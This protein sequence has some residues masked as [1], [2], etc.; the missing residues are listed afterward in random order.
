M[1]NLARKLWSHGK[2]VPARSFSFHRPLLLIQSDDWGRVGVRDREGYEQ[3]RDNGIPLGQNPYDLYTLETA[4]DVSALAEMLRQHRDSTGRSACLLMNFVLANV[5]FPRT[6]RNNYQQIHL[7]SLTEG[8]PGNWKRPG[9]FEAYRKGIGDGL[10]YP[11]LHG[12][13]HFCQQSVR[14]HLAN[15]DER[16]ALLRTL[17]KAETPY[18]YWRMPWV[19]YEY[20]NPEPPRAGFL[21]AQT[22]EAL[23]AAAAESFQEFFSR[24]PL[25]ACAPG[26]RA[27]RETRVAWSKQGVR[28]AQNGSGSPLPPHFDDCEILNLHRTIDVEPSQRELPIEKYVQLA[29]GC[30]ARGVPTIVSVHSIN[31][32]ST[33][34]DFR[35]PTLRALD[36]F[37]SALERKYPD[38]LYVHDADVY[39]IVSRGEFETS[40]GKVSVTVRQAPGEFRSATTT[41]GLT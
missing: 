33:L 6:R 26:Y 5:D 9:L 39:D 1:L 8:L 22:Q 24:P 19:G 36:E 4:E 15:Q 3:L 13:T 38:L 23:I 18:I 31:F 7:R 37:L 30:F 41:E 34:K 29:D 2:D 21:P 35:G 25:S 40:Q 20:C 28:I 14:N 27:N 32:H 12:L 10:F 11:A 17:Y 16:G